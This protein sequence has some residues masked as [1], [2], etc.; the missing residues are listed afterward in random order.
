MS[1]RPL[2]PITERSSFSSARSDPSPPSPVVPTR[3]RPPPPL[4]EISY[5]SEREGDASDDDNSSLSSQR[6]SGETITP[7]RI[8]EGEVVHIEDTSMALPSPADRMTMARPLPIP[9]RSPIDTPRASTPSTPASIN[10]ADI[11]QPG[12]L[13]PPPRSKREPIPLV[14]SSQNRVKR[15]SHVDPYPGGREPIYLDQDIDDEDYDTRSVAT[16]TTAGIAGVGAGDRVRGED[17]TGRMEVEKVQ[18]ALKG[19][20]EEQEQA[21]K[22]YR[23][24]SPLFLL[25]S[26]T[27]RTH[28]HP[29]LPAHAPLLSFTI[30]PIQPYTIYPPSPVPHPNLSIRH[31]SPPISHRGCERRASCSS[32]LQLVG[33]S[34]GQGV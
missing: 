11:P 30:S 18:N 25:S 19:I 34:V 17:M 4:R 2:S 21:F 10:F 20:A 28:P 33:L 29:L 3:S 22:R 7:A 32:R 9:G 27:D 23:E 13:L 15:K 12:G 1:D 16:A 24:V 14:Q 26:L 6:S 5:E 8:L 31:Y